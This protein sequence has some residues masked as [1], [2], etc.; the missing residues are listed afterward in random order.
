MKF[1]IEMFIYIKLFGFCFLSFLFLG[2]GLIL[3]LL[4]SL[5]DVGKKCNF[6][7]SFWL[8]LK[9]QKFAFFFLLLFL[10][11][12]KCMKWDCL[13]HFT[14]CVLLG[15]GILIFRLYLFLELVSTNPTFFVTFRGKVKFL[16]RVLLICYVTR[17]VIL[18][19]R[20]PS[21]PANRN[22][23]RMSKWTQNS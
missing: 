20:F 16:I 9:Y 11:F 18:N 14:Y 1:M 2:L 19:D 21:F 22:E 12:W 3:S 4:N 17:L 7:Q 13:R 8:F 10:P 23:P 5:K 6:S 15:L